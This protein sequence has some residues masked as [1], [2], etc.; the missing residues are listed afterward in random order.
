MCVGDPVELASIVRA[1]R[2]MKSYLD[3]ITVDGSEGGTGAAPLEHQNYVGVPGLSGLYLVHNML[4]G[5]GIRDK[6]KVIMA[7]KITNGMHLFRYLH[8][9]ADICNAARAMMF[10]LGCVQAL[11][12]DT[13]L[14]PTGVTSHNPLRQQ[15]LV[16]ETKAVRIANFQ[17]ATVS[18][19]LDLV[20]A[21][22]FS[23][24]SDIR[25]RPV[26]MMRTSS[27]DAHFSSEL[28]PKLKDGELNE[29][30]SENRPKERLTAAIQNMTVKDRLVRAWIISGDPSLQPRIKLYMRSV[31]T[32]DQEACDRELAKEEKL[33][34]EKIAQ[35]VLLN[36]WDVDLGPDE[37]GKKYQSVKQ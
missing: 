4:R 15:G 3:F 13:D 36:K 31:K 10:A 17:A 2:D 37:A 7:G 30:E 22:G 14:C 23:E 19:C 35:H 24:L 11:Q 21:C 20:A 5:A 32:E 29:V 12:C 33:R 8:M 34:H 26:L 16:P 1:S 9:G 27:T 18:S 25:K 6:T 28:F